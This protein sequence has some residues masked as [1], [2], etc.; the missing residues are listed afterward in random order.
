MHSDQSSSYL[1][2]A[3]AFFA[4]IAVGWLLSNV[5]KGRLQFSLA[6]GASTGARWLVTTKT[7]EMKLKCVCGS[8]MKFC[9][10]VKPGYQPFPT[11]DSVTCPNCGKTMDVTEIRKLEGSAQA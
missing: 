1:L 8:L 11:G 3:I 2:I 7:R 6:P 5:V 4:G 9:D 10:P